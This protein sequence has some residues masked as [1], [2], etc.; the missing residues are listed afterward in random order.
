VRLYDMAIVESSLSLKESLKIIP[1]SAL[2][3]E[4][5]ILRLC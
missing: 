3:I 1:L 2:T 5:N 4:R